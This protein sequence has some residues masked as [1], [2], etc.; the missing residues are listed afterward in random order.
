M[1]WRAITIRSLGDK[2]ARWSL[3]LPIWMPT[4]HTIIQLISGALLKGIG[5]DLVTFGSGV[6]VVEAA[7]HP[8]IGADMLVGCLRA[9][10][11]AEHIDNDAEAAHIVSKV[12]VNH[13]N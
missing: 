4:R 3:F 6:N 9:A 2:S 13:L 7:A 10:E 1:E 12:L 11:R 8:G 5:D